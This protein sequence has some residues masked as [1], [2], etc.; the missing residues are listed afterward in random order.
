MTALSTS[1]RM[2][3]TAQVEGLALEAQQCIYTKKAKL[4]DFPCGPGK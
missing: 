1:E 4:G 3:Y 2:N